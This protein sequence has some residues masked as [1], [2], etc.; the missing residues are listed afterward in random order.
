MLIYQ[1]TLKETSDIGSKLG[2]FDI[3]LSLA[4]TLFDNICGFASYRR[5]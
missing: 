5:H 3:L 2:E 4:I 1:D